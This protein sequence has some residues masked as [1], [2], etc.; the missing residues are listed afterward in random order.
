MRSKRAADLVPWI[1]RWVE[2]GSIIRTDCWKAYSSLSS[3]GYIH[4]T[5]NHSET[6][7]AEN[8]VHTNRI[9]SSWRPLKD[10][11]RK[12]HIRS[13][14]CD[15]QKKFNAAVIEAKEDLSLRQKL[16]SKIREERAECTGCKA[17]END[18]AVK[19]VEYQWRR[20]NRKH[21][22]DS[23]ERLLEAIRNMYPVDQLF[24]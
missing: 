13:V 3:I 4:Q 14:C 6:F 17:N 23:F 15:C 8:G 18:F 2:K 22:Y 12:I 9:E 5:V 20:E 19:I 10:Y 16:Y 11:L 24:D 7:V 21:G 1:E